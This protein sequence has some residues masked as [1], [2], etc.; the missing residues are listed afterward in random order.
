MGFQPRED[1]PAERRPYEVWAGEV[2][3]LFLHGFMGSPKSSRPLAAYLQQYGISTICPLLSGHGHLPYKIRGASHR[4]WLQEAEN[5][6]QM[7]RQRCR[8]VILLGHSM[9]AVLAAHLI[10][11]FG[12]MSGL[13][14]FAPLYDVPDKRIR[15]AHW[16][17][18]LVPYVY[19]LSLK[20]F[21]TDLAIGRVVDFDPSIDLDD[22][23]VQKWLRR[24]TRIPTSGVSEMTKLADLGKVLWSQVHVPVLIMQGKH[25]RAVKPADAQQ[26]YEALP[27]PEKQLLWFEGGHELLRPSDP[28]HEQVWPQV[29]AFI[30]QVTS[31]H[32]G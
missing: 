31:C 26:L 25:D 12:T 1:I 7:I 16:L 30:Q 9:G 24:G 10:H 18:Y 23:A 19:P 32:D 20:S 8:Q 22:P 6:Y 14:T 13:I 2:G 17:R 11:K 3:C 28:V 21:P 15:A 4:Q 29:L 5:A 27:T